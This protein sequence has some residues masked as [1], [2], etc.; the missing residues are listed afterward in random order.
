MGV[1]VQK[2]DHISIDC[3]HDQGA[4]LSTKNAHKRSE[5]L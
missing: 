3:C 4:N 2:G 1:Y 5:S